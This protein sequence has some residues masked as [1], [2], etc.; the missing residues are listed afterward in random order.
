MHLGAQQDKRRIT[1]RKVNVREITALT[2]HEQ[3]GLRAQK[4]VTF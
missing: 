4:E 2:Q 3:Y 1:K